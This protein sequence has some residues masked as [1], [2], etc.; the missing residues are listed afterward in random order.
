MEIVTKKKTTLKPQQKRLNFD[1]PLVYKKKTMNT[2]IFNNKTKLLK[3]Y[4]IKKSKK[5]SL[6]SQKLAPLP[7][8]I[9]ISTLS[10]NH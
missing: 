3:K 5:E 6:K 1:Q 7:P 4:F 9:E 8:P 2:L 10:A